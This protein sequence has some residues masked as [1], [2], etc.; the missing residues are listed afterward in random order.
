MTYKYNS[1]VLVDSA[2]ELVDDL[3]EFKG[4]TLVLHPTSVGL[5]PNE[6]EEGRLFVVLHNDEKFKD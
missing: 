3:M 2:T 6:R 1:L 4:Q 5:T